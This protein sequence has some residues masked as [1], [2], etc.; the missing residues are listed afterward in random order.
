MLSSM[1]VGEKQMPSGGADK[2]GEFFPLERANGS[3]IGLG[4]IF[5]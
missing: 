4:M 5:G 1:R 3:A 2:S